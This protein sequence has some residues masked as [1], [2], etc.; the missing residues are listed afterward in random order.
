MRGECEVLA[1]SLLKYAQSIL[2]KN[3]FI[4]V[5]LVNSSLTP[6]RSSG[7]G[8]DLFNLETT[9]QSSPE[10]KKINVKNAKLGPYCKVDL[11]L[12][13]PINPQ[14]SYLLTK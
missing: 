14:K 10:L 3:I 2:D 1:H 12:Y 7:K 11:Q 8:L 5:K 13:L 6:W 9:K 4:C